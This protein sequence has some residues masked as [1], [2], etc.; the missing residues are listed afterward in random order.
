[1]AVEDK[2]IK[3]KRREARKYKKVTRKDERRI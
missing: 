3:G 1:V 2:E